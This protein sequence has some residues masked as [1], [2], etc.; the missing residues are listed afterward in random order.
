MEIRQ[1]TYFLA[2][3]DTGSF[4]RAADRCHVAQPSL[5]QQ[6]RKLETTLGSVLFD[7][8]PRG[9]V[10]TEAGSALLPR[11]RRII[12]ELNAVDLA[13]KQDI[14]TGA[15][16]LNV[17]AIPTMAPFLLPRLMQRFTRQFPRCTLTLREDFTE[18]LI[19][20][21]VD[22]E[23]DIA[24]MSTPVED[25]ALSIEV[26]GKE[27]LL[28]AAAKDYKLPTAPAN[29]AIGDLRQ[30]PAV[31]L[32]E[33]HCLGQQI[34]S[35]CSARRVTRR[36]VCRSTQLDTVLRLVG[37][38]VGISLV[39]EMCARADLAGACKYYPLGRGGPVRDIAIAWRSDR[40]RSR[41][42]T[43]FVELLRQDIASG[44]QAFR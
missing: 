29:L 12:A 35:F 44:A 8:Q 3:A 42:G 10:L 31:V 1:L 33:M 22:N 13:I 30:Q 4:T 37:L 36:I 15:G 43:A 16:P 25:P 20:A 9:A 21:L 5:S 7:R 17:G 18:R 19:E 6:I 26:L 41:L 39:P 40:S 23:L 14:E 38:G 2:V 24:V 32:H 34:E 28:L 27:R 11:A